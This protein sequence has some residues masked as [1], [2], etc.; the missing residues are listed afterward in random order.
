MKRPP[1]P[2]AEDAG[3]I[4]DEFEGERHFVTALARGLEILRCFRKGEL[5]L[6]NADFAERT[7]LPKATV[8]R[9]TFTLTR[10]GYL[11]LSPDSGR[12]RLGAGVLSLGYSMLSGLDIRTRARPLLQ[13][14]ATA[15]DAS[16]ALGAR[17][18]L[19]MVYLECARG[20][21]TVTLSLDVGSRVTLGTS[22]MGRALLAAL[23]DGE[24]D[25]LLRAMKDRMP[26]AYPRI[27]EGV[28]RAREEI[29]AQGFCTSF[30]DWQADVNAVGVAIL[31]D[32]GAP[33]FGLNCGAPA[34][35]L[36][37]ERL[38]EEFGPRLVEIAA[39]LGRGTV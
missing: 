23:P 6:T 17:D 36:S 14:L 32:E 5:G 19:A 25:Y 35:K 15:A 37:R 16:V 11:T 26:D 7:G 3:W 29:A 4:P 27:V 18:R 8:S 10:L 22:A 38:M 39:I 21:G 9:L 2:I 28:E 34:F 33:I 13:E 1:K 20:P 30:G 12:Y 24:R 31:N